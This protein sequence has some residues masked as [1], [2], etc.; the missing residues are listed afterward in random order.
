LIGVVADG[1]LAHRS[2]ELLVALGA[3]EMADGTTDPAK[4]GAGSGP[5][6]EWVQRVLGLKFASTPANGAAEPPGQQNMAEGLAVWQ[7]A[8]GAAVVSLNALADAVATLDIPE[9]REAMIL[10]RSVRAN[11]TEAP[12]T[13][14]QIDELRR[15]LETDDVIVEAE[16]PNG[17]GISV[18]LRSPLLAALDSLASHLPAT[19]IGAS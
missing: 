19:T 7:Q 14:H 2:S 11:L 13:S 5:K 8:R 16:H 9:A 17:F 3:E 18:S 15:Y 6:V 4:G 12:T 1:R 10:L